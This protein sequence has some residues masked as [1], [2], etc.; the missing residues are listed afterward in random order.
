[1]K[2]HKIFAL[3]LVISI[4]FTVGCASF[5]PMGVIY[6]EVKAPAAVGDTS[7]SAEKVGTAKATSYLGIVATGDASIK[8][9]MENGKITKIHHVD[10]YT[11]NILGIIGEYT[12]TVYGE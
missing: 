1:M 5:V 12:T 4:F 11:K 6:T 2:I 3:L 8:T 10:Y 9:A 7:V